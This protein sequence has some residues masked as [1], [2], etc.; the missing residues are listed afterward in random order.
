MSLLLTPLEWF[1]RLTTSGVV[2]PLILSASK[3][4]SGIGS[5]GPYA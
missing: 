5:Q 4:M 1:D 3:E 2:I